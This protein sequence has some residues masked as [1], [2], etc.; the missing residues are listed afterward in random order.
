MTFPVKTA[1]QFLRSSDLGWGEKGT[2]GDAFFAA[3]NPPFGAVFTYYLKES[4]R[5]Q[6][7]VRRD[8]ERSRQERGEPVFY[9]DWESLRVQLL[10][11]ASGTDEIYLELFAA[12]VLPRL[13]G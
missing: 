2:F 9:P 10:A 1:H 6:R 7:E 13:R 4:L 12:E 5:T 11:Y 3:P 8:E